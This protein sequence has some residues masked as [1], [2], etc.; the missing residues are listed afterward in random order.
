[1]KKFVMITMGL[2]C[3]LVIGSVTMHSKAS[4]D[5]STNGQVVENARRTDMKVD[6]SGELH[7]TRNEIGN[8]PMGEEG[9]WTLFFYICASNLEK[10]VGLST[11]DLT[12]AINTLKEAIVYERHGWRTDGAN[13]LSIAFPMACK[14][15]DIGLL[16]T[17]RNLV[18]SPYYVNFLEKLLYYYDDK[19]DYELSNFTSGNWQSSEYY[20][21]DTI[22]YTNNIIVGYSD[23]NKGV[24]NSSFFSSV[25]FD[26]IWAE[27]YNKTLMTQILEQ[28][29]LVNNN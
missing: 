23:W 28:T 25:Q 7:I 22:D 5:V 9:T 1:M 21:E 15:R 29:N 13:G 27:Q 11:K 19:V 4:N 6:E 8:E 24:K 16:N 3:A 12:E 18:I 2:V 10:R 26:D 17:A 20:F 14:T